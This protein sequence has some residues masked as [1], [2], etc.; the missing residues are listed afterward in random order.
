MAVRSNFRVSD[1]S[2][3]V[4]SIGGISF[5]YLA[6]RNGEKSFGKV[7]MIVSFA[8]SCGE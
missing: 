7:A 4:V 2:S 5:G 6:H 8:T 1:Y 3:L